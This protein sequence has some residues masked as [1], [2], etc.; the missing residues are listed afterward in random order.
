MG[1]VRQRRQPAPKVFRRFSKGP[2][3][4]TLSPTM[5]LKFQMNHPGQYYSE[6]MTTRGRVIAPPAPF[7][8]EDGS[9]GVRRTEPRRKKFMDRGIH[10]TLEGAAGGSTQHWKDPPKGCACISEYYRPGL[11]IQ[12][13]TRLCTQRIEK[14]LTLWP[15]QTFHKGPHGISGQRN[16]LTSRFPW[17][18]QTYVH[19]R[20]WGPGVPPLQHQY[21]FNTSTICICTCSVAAMPRQ[22]G[23]GGAVFSG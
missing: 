10:P 1:C 19:V 14:I 21:L 7:N 9:S 5:N 3:P 8:V 12:H 6:T 23:E 11:T 2:L 16:P 4:I 13:W 15:V 20:R 17:K 18:L 22:D